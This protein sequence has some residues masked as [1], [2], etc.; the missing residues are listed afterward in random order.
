MSSFDEKP[1]S[2]KYPATAILNVE[3]RN[4][5]NAMKS[6]LGLK[7]DTALIKRALAELARAIAE[8]RVKVSLPISEEEDEDDETEE[9]PVEIENTV[10]PDAW[11]P[12]SA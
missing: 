5:F 2:E 11:A 6:R 7:T 1:P 4:E 3:Q 12:T 8:D 10:A 9:A